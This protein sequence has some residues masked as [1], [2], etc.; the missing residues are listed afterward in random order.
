MGFGDMYRITMLVML[1]RLLAGDLY[2]FIQITTAWLGILWEGDCGM[3]AHS[4]DTCT[5]C[6][7]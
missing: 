7:P 6:V 1:R 4:L 2:L 3:V 5:S